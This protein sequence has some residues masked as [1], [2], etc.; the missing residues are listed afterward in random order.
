MKDWL[1]RAVEEE[2]VTKLKKPVRYSA[3]LPNLFGS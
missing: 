2:R 1:E 3:A